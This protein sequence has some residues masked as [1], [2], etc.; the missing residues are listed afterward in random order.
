VKTSRAKVAAIT[1]VIELTQLPVKVLNYLIEI[2]RPLPDALV[3]VVHTTLTLHGRARGLKDDIGVDP[4]QQSIDISAVK[5][6]DGEGDTIHHLLRH[7]RVDATS[8]RTERRSPRRA[9]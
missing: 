9:D 5:G 7:G 4:P 6:L 2:P 8:P 3:S 1:Q